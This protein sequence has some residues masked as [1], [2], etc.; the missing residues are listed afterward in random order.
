MLKYNITNIQ[1]NFRSVS[2]LVKI[3]EKANLSLCLTKHYT[4]KVYGGAYVDPRILDVGNSWRL[5]VRFTPLS[6]YFQ[7]NKSRYP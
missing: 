4:M 6:L 1:V 3:K 7:R 2:C 5:V